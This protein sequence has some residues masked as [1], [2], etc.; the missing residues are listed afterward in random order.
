MSPRRRAYTLIE[1][2]GATALFVLTVSLLAGTTAS[3]I[4]SRMSIRRTIQIDASLDRLI[5][6]VATN[7]YTALLQNSFDPPSR[8]PGDPQNA[9]TLSRSCTTIGASSVTVTWAITPGADSA[10]PSGPLDASDD[11]TITAQASRPDGSVFS[12]TR[13]LAAPLPAY[14]PGYSTLRVL[15]NGDATLLDTPLMLL[16][17][18]GFDTIVDARRPSASG[19]LMLRAPTTACTTASPCR[20][21]LAPGL[22]RGMTDSFTLDA[23]TAVGSSGLVTLSETRLTDLT[24]TVKRVS[25]IVL[26]LDA[27][28]PTG[29]RHTG[30]GDQSPESNSVCACSRSKTGTQHRTSLL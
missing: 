17:G 21:G 1:V 24:V 6:Q 30:R 20:V 2:V 3:V 9:G 22:R 18:A 5:D 27:T 13:V 26:T 12:R 28:H 15:L 7:T 10:N 29:K 11:L 25:Q 8:C 14:R 19:T 23:N 16:S 4:S